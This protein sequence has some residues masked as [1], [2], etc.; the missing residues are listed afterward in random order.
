[1]FHCVETASLCGHQCNHHNQLHKLLV[2][3]DVSFVGVLRNF[4]LIG[5]TWL[6][7]KVFTQQVGVVRIKHLLDQTWLLINSDTPEVNIFLGHR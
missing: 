3:I 5:R 1:M 6:P 2:F 4:R 7:L